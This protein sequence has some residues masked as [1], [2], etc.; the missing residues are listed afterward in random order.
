MSSCV[1]NVPF[2]IHKAALIISL[3]ILLLLALD[4]TL[5]QVLRVFAWDAVSGVFPIDYSIAD[6]LSIFQ[7]LGFSVPALDHHSL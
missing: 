2:A 3:S 1:V 5:C 4:S 6:Q 7:Q